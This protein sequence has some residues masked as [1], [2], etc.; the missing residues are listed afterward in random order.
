MAEAG[1]T[2][3]TPEDHHARRVVAVEGDPAK[4]VAKLLD[5]LRKTSTTCRTSTTTPTSWPTPTT[6]S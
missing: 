6:E 1:F 5:F 4:T 2:P 3:M